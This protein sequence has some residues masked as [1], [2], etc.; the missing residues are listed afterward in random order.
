MPRNTWRWVPV[1]LEGSLTLA[2]GLALHY[3]K[4]SSPNPLVLLLVAGIRRVR[5]QHSA[6]LEENPIRGCKLKNL[7]HQRGR[8]N[9]G[10]K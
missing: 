7:H 8:V 9:R 6:K 3:I 5:Y 1:S 10:P 4:F 2:E